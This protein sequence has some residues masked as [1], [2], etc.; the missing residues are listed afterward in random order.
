MCNIRLGLYA[1]RQGEDTMTREQ[2]FNSIS[3]CASTL[4]KTHEELMREYTDMLTQEAGWAIK[5]A[6]RSLAD[7]HECLKEA[8]D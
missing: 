5:D 3:V 8:G 1:Y 6:L 7:A 2:A 4:K